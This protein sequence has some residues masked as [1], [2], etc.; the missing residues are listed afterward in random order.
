MEYVIIETTEDGK[1]KMTV[2][3][4]QELINKAYNKGYEDGKNKTLLYYPIT[5]PAT[6]YWDWT[7]P[8]CTSFGTTKIEG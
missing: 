1:P 3:E 4:I 7:K 2:Q 6:P 5:T 8:Y